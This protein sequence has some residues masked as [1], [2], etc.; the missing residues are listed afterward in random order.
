MSV[1]VTLLAQTIFFVSSCGDPTPLSLSELKS[2]TDIDGD[3]PLLVTDTG[4]TPQDTALE[5][6]DTAVGNTDTDPTPA[7]QLAN[8]AGA[9]VDST[10]TIND[11]VVAD[12]ESDVHG[13][14]DI[15]TPQDTSEDT[16]RV[17]FD[18]QR[19]CEVNFTYSAPP[20]VSSVSVRNEVVGWSSDSWALSDD[21]GDGTW[22]GSYTVKDYT[23]GS[24]GYKFYRTG[25]GIV[26][27]WVLDP[28]NPLQKIVD[29]VVNSK[30]YIPNC[31]I[32][33]I[34][35]LSLNTDANTGSI[36][37]S[38]A[39]QDGLAGA[40]IP[41]SVDVRVGNQPLDSSVYDPNSGMVEIEV[42][43]LKPGKHSI[44][45]R[46]ANTGGNADPLF[47]PIWI[48]PQPFDW[49]QSV[50]YFAFVD[51]FADGAP[52]PQA[53]GCLPQGSS[54]T[55]LGGDWVGLKQKITDGYFSDLGVTAL[56]ITAPADNPDGC[57][58]GELQKSYSAYHGYFPQSFT[59]VENRFGTMDDLRALVSAAHDRGIR[60]LVDLVAN[61]VFQDHP[62][63]SQHPEWFFPYYQCGFD[64]KPVECWF[65]PYLPDIDYTRDG[66]I[67]A[68]TDMALWWIREADL[69][70]FRVDAVKHVHDNFMLTLRHKINTLLGP[71]GVPFYLVGE[72]FTGDWGGGFGPN[73][74]LIKYYVQPAMLDGQFD[75]PLYWKIVRTYG[76]NEESMESLGSYL[77]NISGY[78]GNN[79]VMSNFL[80]NHDVA[81]FTSHAAGHIGDVWGNGSKAQGFDN[82]PP[83]PTN[84]E[85][86]HRLR[87][88]FALMFAVNGIPLIY[89]GDEIGLAG[90]G[91]PDNR[92]MMTFTDW[93]QE[94]QTT[95][96]YLGKLAAARADHSALWRGTI[97]VLTSGNDH[98]MA[99]AKVDKNS[100]VIVVTNRSAS[101][102][103][104]TFALPDVLKGNTNLVDALSGQLVSAGA[105]QATVT[106]E[107]Y[108]TL[109]LV[110]P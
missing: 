70:G 26:D 105:T 10:E 100:A 14:T 3:S 34:S 83:Q 77:V 37:A 13:S 59:S 53:P 72:T 47:V 73:E 33:L 50:L 75:F 107:P 12:S 76:R 32:P 2:G 11:I 78:Y 23:P 4:V 61:H 85:P 25:D 99:F 1:S 67:E 102:H 90:A 7:D 30:F 52:G 36:T 40:T 92:R 71:S 35:V 104:L 44:L 56:W 91:D 86:Y 15:L 6:P 88:A 57:Y 31:S 68:F 18:K 45:V 54:T 109:Y 49:A 51:R 5:F 22:I 64:E 55:W 29:N 48:E 69:D 39:I 41:S 42:K 19:K 46:A 38:I 108:E 101:S 110:A 8:D 9:H 106:I 89:Y 66:A 60:I 95:Y 103:V 80:G 94:Q 81:R 97:Q 79:A 28:A 87:A 43:G 96:D 82:P 84:S 20:G 98:A 24:Y 27:N 65:Q 74:T 21:D 63:V 93:S 16:G 17:P 58:S 62:A